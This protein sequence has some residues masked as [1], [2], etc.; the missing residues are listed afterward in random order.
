MSVVW[1]NP[2]IE[3]QDSGVIVSSNQLQFDKEY[4]IVTNVHNRSV[5]S[6]AIGVGVHF[7]Y[8]N[9]GIGGGWISIGQTKVDI[10]VV[11]GSSNPALAR[12][13]WRTPTTPGHYCIKCN[14]TPPDDLNWADNEG[15]ENTDVIE[16]SPGDLELLIPV[17]NDKD[18]EIPIILKVD[19]YKL[20]EKPLAPGVDLAFLKKHGI[21]WNDKFKRITTTGEPIKEA[22]QGR[23]VS[24]TLWDWL[25][26][27]GDA[28]FLGKQIA[29]ARE[30]RLQRMQEVIK[31]NALGGF[32]V[33]KEWNVVLTSDI[34]LKPQSQTDACFSFR[35]PL[36]TPAGHEQTFNIVALDKDGNLMGGVTLVTR[37]KE[38]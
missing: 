11:G 30:W 9:W 12:V 27:D 35:V 2:D 20:P 33:P 15:Q 3:L 32:P 7:F 28:E 4:D 26:G 16:V 31:A 18:S 6:P 38:L 34:K 13:K 1:N 5:S 37:V 25:L 21:H 23:L 8:R 19:A 10:S 22:S 17:F 24:H 14:L 29:A 36:D